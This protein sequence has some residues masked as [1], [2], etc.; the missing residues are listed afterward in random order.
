MPLL[1]GLRMGRSI[2]K[3]SSVQDTAVVS[4]GGGTWPQLFQSRSR[5]K[6]TT[7]PEKEKEEE[8][9]IHCGEHLVEGNGPISSFL[10]D[11]GASHLPSWVVGT[12]HCP[13]HASQR[14]GIS[15][16]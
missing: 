10:W 4:A 6:T 1:G 12:M 11:T 14:E 2:R 9:L 7:H 15:D 5:Q 13:I 8:I 16:S 3:H